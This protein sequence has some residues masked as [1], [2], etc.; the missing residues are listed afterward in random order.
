MRR[1][2]GENTPPASLLHAGSN[3]TD[4]MECGG[5]VDCDDRV[6]LFDRKT[7]SARHAGCG[8]VDEHVHGQT[9]SRQTRSCW[10]FPLARPYSRA[11]R[12]PSPKT[13][14]IAVRVF[15]HRRSQSVEHDVGASTCESPRYAR[16][17]PLV[18]PVTTRLYLSE[19]PFRLSLLICVRSMPR[20]FRTRAA[21][22][23]RPSCDQISRSSGAGVETGC[24][25]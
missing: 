6:P 21:D 12:S 9:S 19:Y 10:R 17:M 1:S 24:C 16:P 4:A 3:G 22:R 5:E 18:E 13:L 11:N 20:C 23:G 25:R 15:S 8:I 7:R 2:R 14:S